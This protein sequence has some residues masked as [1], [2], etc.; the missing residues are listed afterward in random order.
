[1]KVNALC[2]LALVAWFLSTLAGVYSLDETAIAF[3]NILQHYIVIKA[4]NYDPTDMNVNDA[5]PVS[6]EAE[7]QELV[8][9]A[10]GNL[11]G[12]PVTTMDASGNPYTTF[13]ASNPASP[14]EFTYV[15]EHALRGCALKLTPQV[16]AVLSTFPGVTVIP[17]GT[18][19]PHTTRTP[20]FLGLTTGNLWSQSKYGRDVIV[21]V[22]DTGVWPESQSFNDTGMQ[23][24]CFSVF[25]W[26]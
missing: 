5:S 16:A 7:F 19:D 12:N 9:S 1:M 13:D 8:N 4:A 25:T 21:G 15:F 6:A 2:L 26:S 14:V 10:M 11:S 24:F 20:A 17:D 18:S 3:D 23:W 22:I